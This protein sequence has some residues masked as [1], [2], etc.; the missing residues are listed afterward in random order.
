MSVSIKD[1]NHWLAQNKKWSQYKSEKLKKM[2][3]KH[4]EEIS[5]TLSQPK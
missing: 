1:F 4:Q 2:D 3:E 5:A